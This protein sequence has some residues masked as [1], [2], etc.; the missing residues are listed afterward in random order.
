[1]HLIV[2]KPLAE[3]Q[4]DLGFRLPSFGVVLRSFVNLSLYRLAEH[5]YRSVHAILEYGSRFYPQ[6]F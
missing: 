1:M 2:S 4:F 3:D 5:L 6:D